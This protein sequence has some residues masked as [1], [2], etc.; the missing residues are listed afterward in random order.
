MCSTHLQPY[1]LQAIKGYHIQPRYRAAPFIPKFVPPATALENPAGAW[2]QGGDTLRGSRAPQL[3]AASTPS[4][5]TEAAESRN[6]QYVHMCLCVHVYASITHTQTYITYIIN[7][8]IYIY[9]HT[10]LFSFMF[11]FIYLET[12]YINIINYIIS[13][14]IYIYT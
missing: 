13:I 4:T 3:H 9:I 5:R 14:H 2:E 1:F 10:H 7:I 11:I 6:S 12:I 8:Y